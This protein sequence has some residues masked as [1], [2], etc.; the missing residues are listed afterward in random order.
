MNLLYQAVE[1]LLRGRS[2]VLPLAKKLNVF[3]IRLAF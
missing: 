2:A 3:K 1:K